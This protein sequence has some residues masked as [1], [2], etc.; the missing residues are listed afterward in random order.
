MSYI[1]IRLTRVKL[2]RV[3]YSYF[4]FLLNTFTK[5]INIY[6]INVNV[7]INS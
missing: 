6:F 7:I 3:I 2:I 1:K 4:K 5:Y